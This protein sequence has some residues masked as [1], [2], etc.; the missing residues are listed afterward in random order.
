MLRSLPENLDA[1]VLGQETCLTIVERLSRA[2]FPKRLWRAVLQ[3]ETL[4]LG[5]C[6]ETHPSTKAEALT[7]PWQTSTA[8]G[9]ARA[10][11]SAP[12][13]P[14]ATDTAASPGPR[15][16]RQSAFDTSRTRHSVL[17]ATAA[18]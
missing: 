1:P 14:L 13:R 4:C 2:V 16:P 15:T 7:A 8:A 17:P 3:Q 12:R 11:G 9:A 5:T 6:A 10:S 18:G